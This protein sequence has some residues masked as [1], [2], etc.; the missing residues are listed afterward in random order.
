MRFVLLRTR[1]SVVVLVL[2]AKKIIDRRYTQTLLEIVHTPHLARWYR[3]TWL[4]AH[5]A[6]EKPMQCKG[7]AS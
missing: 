5:T 1:T 7:P 6:F 3:E 2:S 4:I